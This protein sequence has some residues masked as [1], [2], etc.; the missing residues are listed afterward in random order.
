LWVNEHAQFLINPEY[1]LRRGCQTAALPMGMQSPRLEY[2]RDLTDQGASKRLSQMRITLALCARTTV[3]PR[4]CVKEEA[5]WP[6]DTNCAEVLGRLACQDGPAIFLPELISG[7]K[8]AGRRGAD[9]LSAV[10]APTSMCMGAS[11][12]D[13]GYLT[14]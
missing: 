12:E 8:F 13:V 7:Q 3:S 5:R 6:S 10:R 14:M 2:C 11:V 9:A 1:L 4:D